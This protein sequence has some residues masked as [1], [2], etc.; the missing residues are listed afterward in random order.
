MRRARPVQFEGAAPED[1]TKG[2]MPS[3]VTDEKA[4]A[5]VAQEVAPMLTLS[6]RD[7][8]VET[9][10]RDTKGSEQVK[11]L[12]GCSGAVLP[13]ELL[14]IMGPSGSG[15][16]TLLKALAGIG[17]LPLSA[18]E[19]AVNGSPWSEAM[20]A[21]CA[22][23]YQEELF[24]GG[25]TVKEHLMYQSQLR[26][27]WKAS[28]EQLRRI[29]TLIAE[30]GLI[31]CQHT[32]IGEIGSG[33]SGGERKRLAFAS[34]LLMDP[35][36]LL[37]DEP[38]SGLD[39][40]MAQSVVELLRETAKSK[41]QKRTVCTTIHQPSSDVFG[42]FDK[43]LILVNGET[44]FFGL[45]K[46][47][48]GH[49]TSL[50]IQ[51]PRDVSP[52]DFFMR[53]VAVDGGEE[54]SRAQAKENV[55]ALLASVE[56]L[57]RPLLEEVAKVESNVV[58]TSPRH[59]T[60]MMA[61]ISTLVRREALLRRRSKLLF[62][63]VIA[64]TLIMSVLLGLLYFDISHD[65]AGVQSMMGAITILMINTF[66]TSGFG[67]TQELP[68]SLRPA[69]RES[70]LGMYSVSAWFW[71]K[72]IGDIPMDTVVPFI[73]ITITFW[74]IR[75]RDSAGI[76]V[77]FSILVVLVS[78]MGSSWG[79]MCSMLGGRTEVAFAV[80]FLS[81]FPMFMF[82]G[83]LIPSDQVPVYFRWLEVIV[84][85]KYAFSQM[86]IEIWDG[87]GPVD[88]C[89]PGKCR[90]VDG[91]HVLKAFDID[92]AGT[93]INIIVM[94][95]YMVGARLLAWLFAVLRGSPTMVRGVVRRQARSA[96]A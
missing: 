54:E 1:D 68:L 7:V 96:S 73:G 38:T 3:A 60:S 30:L 10:R 77:S 4:L 41:S 16:T 82:S 84:P 67:L 63:A 94:L 35:S 61:Q 36:L 89:V 33:I 49:F 22:F 53:S 8:Q 32:L 93:A 40:S 11:I 5:S 9:Q 18:G 24:F 34:E 64:R 70:R 72:T 45:T 71:A 75:L 95:A 6:W 79:Y 46:D 29:D 74:C 37:L 48:L 20:R 65:Q 12:S 44:V 27:A 80:F 58:T 66:M 55:K 87:H 21:H 50:G 15:K 26:T 92:K 88:G 81:V 56:Q 85:F 52:P 25:L 19:V 13:G 86:A 91:D 43:L 42:L 59:H 76:W 31:T 14:A 57:A 2:E 28:L 78:L 62:K 51:C 17:E 83:F 69:L 90:F 23:L 47:V 39:S